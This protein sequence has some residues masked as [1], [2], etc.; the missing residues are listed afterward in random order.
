MGTATKEWERNHGKAAREEARKRAEQRLSE[1]ENKIVKIEKVGPTEEDIENLLERNKYTFQDKSFAVLKR[2]YT[3]MKDDIET[4]TRDTQMKKRPSVSK[5]AI[6][7][8]A[9]T[10]CGAITIYVETFGKS[11]DVQYM[12]NQ[13]NNALEAYK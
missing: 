6:I 12:W 13:A 4:Y 5:R 11:R 2:L 3:D 7:S 8:F 10:L 9:D 1:P